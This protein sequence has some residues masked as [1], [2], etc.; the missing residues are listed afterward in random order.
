M[1]INI[2]WNNT[3]IS[4]EIENKIIKK[5]IKKG[6]FGKINIKNNKYSKVIYSFRRN[7]FREH[8]I[9][10]YWK[11]KKNIRKINKELFK[12]DILFISKKY[13]YP[14]VTIIRLIMES[15]G[16]SK[17]KINNILTKK[18]SLK[19]KFSRKQLNIALENDITADINQSKQLESSRNFELKVNHEFDKYNIKYFTEEQLR[20]KGT[21][22]T[23]DLLLKEPIKING[24]LIYWVDAKDY[25]GSNLKII[26]KGLKKQSSKYNNKFG[27]GAFVFH[28]GFSEKLNIKNTLLLSL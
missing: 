25:Y 10:N 26:T 17:K 11:I 7:Y 4:S 8:L 12:N 19:K 3:I 20:E 2:E 5:Y 28:Y 13:N 6:Y 23:P 16:F 22:L 1:V 15:N 14:P 18:E 21:T 9:K 24:T 27:K